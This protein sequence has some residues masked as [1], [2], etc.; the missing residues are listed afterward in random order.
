LDKPVAEFLHIATDRKSIT[1]L[2]RN[3]KGKYR[4][5]YHDDKAS[6]QDSLGTVGVDSQ[7][8]FSLV[9]A[10]AAKVKHKLEPKYRGY[11]KNFLVLPSSFTEEAFKGAEGTT[12]MTKIYRQFAHHVREGR[13]YRW[14]RPEEYDKILITGGFMVSTNHNTGWHSHAALAVIWFNREADK[15]QAMVETYDSE[16]PFESRRTG[17]MKGIGLT[18]GKPEINGIKFWLRDDTGCGLTALG[19]NVMRN[20]SRDQA[21]QHDGWNCGEYVYRFAKC[22]IRGHDPTPSEL[23]NLH[24]PK[25]EPDWRDGGRTAGKKGTYATKYLR[26]RLDAGGQLVHP[27]LDEVTRYIDEKKKKEMDRLLSYLTMPMR[28]FLIPRPVPIPQVSESDSP[29]WE[30]SEPPSPSAMLRSKR[31]PLKRKK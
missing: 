30:P 16:P 12:N 3:K 11:A 27:V 5:T 7:I 14:K 15:P 9:K 17:K 28:T 21:V 23:P 8:V 13:K 24:V 25:G 19:W 18:F 2:I 1:D 31:K 6:E 26:G 20:Y 29:E 4:P 10:Y 22:I